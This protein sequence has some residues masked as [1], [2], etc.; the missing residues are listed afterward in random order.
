M[1][2]GFL[3]HLTN[4][5]LR[6]L[7]W[8]VFRTNFWEEKTFFVELCAA[9]PGASVGEIAKRIRQKYESH[10]SLSQRFS[11]ARGSLRGIAEV[12]IVFV[13]ACTVV[14]FKCMRSDIHLNA[15]I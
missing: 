9:I 1:D 4:F 11:H 7:V 14:L 10:C 13:F 8:G 15:C 5:E 3:L 12:V 6:F 2:R